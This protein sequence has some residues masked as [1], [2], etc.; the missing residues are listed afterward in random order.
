L[1]VAQPAVLVERGAH[2]GDYMEGE[3]MGAEPGGEYRDAGGDG[4]VYPVG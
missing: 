4:I 2:R 3:A 1:P